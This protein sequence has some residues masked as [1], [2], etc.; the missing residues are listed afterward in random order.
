MYVGQGKYSSLVMLGGREFQ[1]AGALVLVL[2]FRIIDCNLGMHICDHQYPKANN[3]ISSLECRF[4]DFDSATPI[5]KS[6]MQSSVS[7]VPSY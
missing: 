6:E 1:W 4:Y 2:E 3:V 7:W 5:L